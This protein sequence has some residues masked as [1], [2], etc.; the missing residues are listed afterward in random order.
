MALVSPIRVSYLLTFPAFMLTDKY[1]V[2]PIK[3]NARFAT[4]NYGVR[5]VRHL[6]YSL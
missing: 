1:A 4:P 6:V 2:L 3:N 5:A